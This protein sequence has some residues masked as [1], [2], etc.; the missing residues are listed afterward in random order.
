MAEK[1]K[2]ANTVETLTGLT[3]TQWNPDST[4]MRVQTGSEKFLFLLDV[5]NRWSKIFATKLE[6]QNDG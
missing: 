5:I 4:L 3:E 2:H 1:E 6:V